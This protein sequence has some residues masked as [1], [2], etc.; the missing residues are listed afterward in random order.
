MARIER[1]AAHVEAQ[2]AEGAA[3]KA[4]RA[5]GGTDAGKGGASESVGGAVVGVGGTLDASA[6]DDEGLPRADAE[7]NPEPRLS[8]TQRK[9]ARRAAFEADDAAGRPVRISAVA[10]DKI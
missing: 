3:C 2:S 5:A 1:V 9:A 10:Y 4:R 6:C 7:L 8:K